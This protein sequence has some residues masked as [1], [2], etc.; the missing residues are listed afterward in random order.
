[1]SDKYLLVTAGEKFYPFSHKG[2]IDLNT[3]HRL[4]G[5]HIEVVYPT[6]EYDLLAIGNEEARIFGQSE[7]TFATFLA[8]P[9]YGYSMVGDFVLC[10]GVNSD[11]F[12]GLDDEAL[13]LTSLIYMVFGQDVMHF[14]DTVEEALAKRAADRERVLGN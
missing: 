10:S 3:W 1:M 5:G 14:E 11:H 6:D 8:G 2:E 12:H 7:N 13:N 9:K 4:V